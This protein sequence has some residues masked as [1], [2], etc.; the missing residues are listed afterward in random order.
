M[1]KDKDDS[2]GKYLDLNIACEDATENIKDLHADAKEEEIS[3][4]K[5]GTSS[6]ASQSR[7]HCQVC[8][9]IHV[10]G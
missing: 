9:G 10:Q 2:D 8:G 7:S 3:K 4:E 1:T 6:L 5:Y